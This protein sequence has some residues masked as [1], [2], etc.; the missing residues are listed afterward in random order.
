VCKIILG[1]HYAEELSDDEQQQQ[2][3]QTILIT[4]SPAKSQDQGILFQEK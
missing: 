3:K 2:Q 4:G 1:H